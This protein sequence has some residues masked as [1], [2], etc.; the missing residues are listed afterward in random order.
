MDT[1]TVSLAD[2]YLTYLKLEK[3]A[4][5]HSLRL[6]E[7]EVRAWLAFCG[8]PLTASR[9][10]AYTYLAAMSAR[11]LKR[12]SMR[13]NWSCIRSFYTYLSDVA[14]LPVTGKAHAVKVQDKEQ[15][16]PHVISRAAEAKIVDATDLRTV[17]GRRDR[18]LLDLL[19]TT[20][21]RADEIVTLT[22]D[23]VDLDEGT[24]IVVGKGRKERMIPFAEQDNPYL[25]KWI[26]EDRAKYAKEG[27]TALFVSRSGGPL[28]YKGLYNAVKHAG[29]KAGLSGDVSPH[30]FRHSMATNLLNHDLDIRYIQTI[31]GHARLSTTETYTHVASEDVR[32]RYLQAMG[33][34]RASRKR[35][36]HGIQRSDN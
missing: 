6:A 28:L 14:E 2:K 35:S 21:A 29:K 3:Q 9:D 22:V 10:T 31:L 5:P 11:G 15:H 20:G 1:A 32:D 25:R 26:T 23:R 34:V 36:T 30:S 12:S 24:I 27:C 17:M 16:L 18:A 19:R 4:S 13:T 33:R 7:R 8:D